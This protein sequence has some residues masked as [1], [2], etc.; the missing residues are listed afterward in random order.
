[1]RTTGTLWETAT[2]K[3]SENC[4]HGR[5]TE[6]SRSTSARLG[7]TNRS[8]IRG[9][10]TT[11]AGPMRMSAG[12]EAGVGQGETVPSGR[13]KPAGSGGFQPEEPQARNSRLARPWWE[14]TSYGL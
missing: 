10:R 6:N 8:L 1:M 3:R 4:H 13:L 7:I 14:R 12:G 2:L 9:E 5:V 11:D